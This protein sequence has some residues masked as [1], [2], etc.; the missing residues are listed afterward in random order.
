MKPQRRKKLLPA[1]F[2]R[3]DALVLA[4]KLLGQTLWHDEI[5]LR[6]TETEAYCWPHDTANHCHKGPTQRNAPMWG[7]PGHAYIYLCYGM[8]HMLNIVSNPKG[9]GA[10]VLIRSCEPL[11]GLKTVQQ[12]RKGLKGKALLNGPGKVAQALGIDGQM[13]HMPLFRKGGL[14]LRAGSQPQS[15]FAGPRVGIGYADPVHR[16]APWRFADGQSEW[17]SHPKNLRPK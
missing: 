8:H 1:S 7:P 16:D 11:A 2:F 3:A 9:E 10:A 14:E 6:I 17:V 12:R 13:N 4:Q 5:G 15:I